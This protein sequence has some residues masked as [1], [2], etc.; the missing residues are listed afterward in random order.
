MIKSIGDLTIILLNWQT[1]V[2]QNIVL[3]QYN[4]APHCPTKDNSTQDFKKIKKTIKFIK[5]DN[6]FSYAWAYNNSQSDFC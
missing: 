4:Y 3:F 5:P 6:I 1:T 2:Q